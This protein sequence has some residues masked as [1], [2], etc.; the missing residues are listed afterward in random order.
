MVAKR[1][2]E[3][4]EARRG[5]KDSGIYI[6][7]ASLTDPRKKKSGLGRRMKVEDWLEGG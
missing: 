6:I 5:F 7:I 4:D 1:G 2:N 3:E